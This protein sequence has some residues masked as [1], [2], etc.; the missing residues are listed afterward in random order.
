MSVINQFACRHQATLPQF[1]QFSSRPSCF[2]K[3][4]QV[5]NTL[6]TAMSFARTTFIICISYIY[7]FIHDLHCNQALPR[8]LN[9]NARSLSVFPNNLFSSMMEENPS[10]G[11]YYLC[12]ILQNT[13]CTPTLHRMENGLLDDYGENTN[14][15][16]SSNYLLMVIVSRRED[17]LLRGYPSDVGINL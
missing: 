5:S 14:I 7:L 2:H 16:E 1:E 11:S 9:S 8:V 6:Q 4:G 3:T 12:L 15:P 17:H 10:N 13:K